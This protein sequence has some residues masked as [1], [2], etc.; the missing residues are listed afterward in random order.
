MKFLVNAQFPVRLAQ[1]LRS[2]GY[3]TLHTKDLLLQNATK[4]SEINAISI[5]EHRIVIT[6]D[7]DFWDSFLLRQEPY[8]LLL[9]TTGNITNNE[10]LE[11]F[12]NNLPKL[13]E[14]F[15]DRS[16]IEINRDT[17]IVHQ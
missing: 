12:Q 4:D 7:R 6:K 2:A 15:H 16:L 13:I 10:L 1:F 8:K 11:L 5:Q 3:D 9:V 14:L 17:I